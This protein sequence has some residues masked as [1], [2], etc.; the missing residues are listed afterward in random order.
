MS[1]LQAV[2]TAP[3]MS[4][5]VS[6]TYTLTPAANNVDE[7]SSLTFTVGGTNIVNGTYYWSIT[8]SGTTNEDFAA[9]N[10]TV[11]VT[12]N[13][14]SFTITATA[15]TTT[16][17]SETFIV[18]LR[19][20]STGG[21]IL[22]SSGS[23]TIN[24]T[25]TTPIVRLTSGTAL[26]FN[27]VD[28]RHV[29]V[30]D[31]LTDWN[32]G[33]NWTIEWWHNIPV[34]AGGFLSV[35]CQDANV[36]SFSGIDVFIN[37]GSICMFNGYRQ[38]S[39]SAATRGVWNHIALQKNGT[40]L[41][42]YINGVPQTFNGSHSGTIA[43]SSPMNVCIGSRTYDGGANFYGQYFNGQLANIRI[44]TV[45]RYT[46]IFT[47]PTTVEYDQYTMLAL[48]GSVGSGGML[49]D[50]LTRHTITN[51]GATIES[52]VG[53][54]QT[55]ADD[56]GGGLI[57]WGPGALAIAYD[58]NIITTYPVGSTITFQNGDVRSIVGYDPYAPNYIDVFWIG[59]TTSSPLFPITLY[60]A[61]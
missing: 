48:D 36:G 9:T 32:L 23:I 56:G 12:S 11:S 10:G 4:S 17:G 3:L 2:M 38:T 50:E 46:T 42:A 14:G 35:L 18:A 22:A 39:E 13:S 60:Q 52:T 51:V 59:T 49:V 15:D 30:A 47:P 16:E 31:N 53:S 1:I 21:T 7:N 19:E 29:I 5:A 43:P 24:D 61:A 57:G 44:S 40:D 34:G 33:D 26:G 41:T 25:S 8:N 54:K 58:A 6:P 55:I 28:N 20:G 27:G 37:N 45:A